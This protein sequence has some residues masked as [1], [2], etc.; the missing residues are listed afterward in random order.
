MLRDVIL[1]AEKTCR[2]R[3]PLEALGPN[4]G[5]SAGVDE[6][7][8]DADLIGDAPEAAFDDIL[9]LELAAQLLHFYGLLLVGEGAVASQYPQLI[10]AT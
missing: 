8:S 5:T 1:Y 9:R 10:E 6:L 2:C 7:R 4:V 3:R